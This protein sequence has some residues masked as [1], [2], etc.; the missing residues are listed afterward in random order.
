MT[1]KSIRSVRLDNQKV[2]RAPGPSSIGRSKNL[3]KN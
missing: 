2:L 1:L 3:I